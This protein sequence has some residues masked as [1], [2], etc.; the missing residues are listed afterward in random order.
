MGKTQGQTIGGAMRRR[1]REMMANGMGPPTSA[2]PDGC[3]STSGLA[4]AQAALTVAASQSIDTNNASDLDV[5]FAAALSA[6]LAGELAMAQQGYE[7]YLQQLGSL[8]VVRT[9]LAGIYLNQGRLD[10]ADRLLALALSES[11]DY[12]EALSNRGY[13]G[14]LKGQ[15]DQAVADLERALLLSPSLL[16]ALT[17]L[18]PLYQQQGREREAL[19][20]LDQALAENPDSASLHDL[21]AQVLVGLEGAAS[22]LAHLDS[23]RDRLSGPDRAALE[24]ARGRLLLA[25]GADLPAALQA[26]EVAV[27][28]AVKPPLHD[29]I[30]KG[31]ALRKLNRQSEALNWINTCLHSEGN[32]GGLLNLK[33]CILQDMQQFEDAILLYRMAAELE[34][35]NSLYHSNLGFAYSEVGSHDLAISTFLVGLYH[36]PQSSAL[37]HGLAQANFHLGKPKTAYQYYRQALELAPEN[38]NI[39]DN[40]LYFLSFVNSISDSQSLRHFHDYAIKGLGPRLAP[41]FAP[42]LHQWSSPVGRPL[43]IGILSAE[44]GSHCVSY[45]LL[46]L[47][48]GASDDQAE[49]YVFP[50]K[51]RSSEPRWS[52]VQQRAREFICIEQLSDHDACRLIR[53]FN[54]DVVLETSQHMVA[55][56]LMLM[57]HRLAPVQA[58]Y[59]GMHGTTGVPAIDYFIGD[60]LITPHDFAPQFTERL[61][62]LPR[63]WVAY[64]PPEEGLPPIRATTGHPPLRLGCFNNVSK[65]TRQCLR[66]WARVLEALPDATL[67]IKDSLRSGELDHQRNAIDYLQCLG[68][69]PLRINVVPRTGSWQ[70]HMD[71]YND[72]DI[73]LDAL[74]LT[75]GTTAFDALLMGTPLVAYSTPWIGGRLSASIVNGL[76]QSDWIADSPQRYVE[77]I[78]HLA[79]DLKGLRASRSARREQFLA[80]ELCDQRGLATALIEQLR[81]AYIAVKSV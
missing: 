8:V 22:A 36:H 15:H 6:H 62:R 25:E 56:R 65:I 74:P 52:I 59:I 78:Q 45:F 24:S 41:G 21:K 44:I 66:V 11:P 54:L 27:A 9:N 53:G 55:N 46:S 20:R 75:S 48:L 30:N 29:L 42:F 2:E 76:G 70:E 34:P 43:R 37:H 35:S 14:L 49:F 50:T 47:L 17:N 4:D 26:F 3:S 7:R 81:Q 32:Q 77:L 28:G 69:D 57:A 31:E 61:M 51:N 71:L 72:L 18:I 79:A 33:A 23:V 58:H 73:A 1:K 67:M 10:D 40:F 16:P 60:E 63:T 68:I 5:Q 19:E 64:T 39:W 38:L 13:L 12:S 80:S